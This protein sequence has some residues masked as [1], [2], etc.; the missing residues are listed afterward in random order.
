MRVCR[1]L[2]SPVA[3]L[4]VLVS[5]IG[6][7]ANAEGASASCPVLVTAQKLL[8]ETLLCDEILVPH[9]WHDPDELQIPTTYIVL[10]SPSFAPQHDLA[11]GI[12][13]EPGGSALYSVSSISSEAMT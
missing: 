12:Q 13:G 4:L 6:D 11:I 2:N 5:S 9:D 7:A 1:A 3:A 10:R 8:S